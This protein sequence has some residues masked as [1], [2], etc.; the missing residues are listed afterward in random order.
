MMPTLGEENFDQKARIFEA[1]Q[2]SQIIA[3]TEASAGGMKALADQQAATQRAVEERISMLSVALG[4]EVQSDE[5][6]LVTLV[7][8]MTRGQRSNPAAAARTALAELAA[9]REALKG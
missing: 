9:I 3:K 6:L 5:T 2:R 8:T 1:W 7:S 4:P